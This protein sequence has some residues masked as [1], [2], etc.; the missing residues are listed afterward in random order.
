MSIA[1]YSN[2]TLEY[3]HLS[4]TI[5]G[6]CLDLH[7]LHDALPEPTNECEI[8]TGP[9]N[10]YYTT[11][12]MGKEIIACTPHKKNKYEGMGRIEV[13][14]VCRNTIHLIDEIFIKILNNLDFLSDM[15]S[16]R[17]NLYP[18]NLIV[19]IH[20]IFLIQ[21]H[22]KRYPI[23]KLIVGTKVGK[24]LKE[25]DSKFFS[26]NPHCNEHQLIGIL[27]GDGSQIWGKNSFNENPCYVYETSLMNE[28][29][30]YF[31][32][33]DTFTGTLEWSPEG[34]AGMAILNTD[35]IAKL[36]VNLTNL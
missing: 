3:N 24:L 20:Q 22:G 33:H 2:Y 34:K 12:Q 8:L 7:C 28:N 25:F 17:K 31:L 16:V 18:T 19:L 26:P 29:E 23:K 35:G 6:K 10:P 9:K 32:S 21:V 15:T 13:F 4:S 30:I 11:T 5:A 27:W 36:T 1:L 14:P